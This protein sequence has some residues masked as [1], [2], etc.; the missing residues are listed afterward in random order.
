M[1]DPFDFGI[2][3]RFTIKKQKSGSLSTAAFLFT[4][5]VFQRRIA[6]NAATAQ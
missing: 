6:L 2:T 5:F 1:L 4:I 3:N